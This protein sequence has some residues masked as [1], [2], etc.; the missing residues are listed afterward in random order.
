MYFYYYYIDLGILKHV[1]LVLVG[2]S[3]VFEYITNIKPI[4]LSDAATNP[5]FF[6]V[7]KIHIY[8]N[9]ETPT[10]CNGQISV[11]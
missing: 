6:K 2:H 3:C 11:L 9:I 5:A 8:F 4:N 1:A 10:H 7:F